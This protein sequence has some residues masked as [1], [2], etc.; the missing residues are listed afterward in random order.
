MNFI[1]LNSKPNANLLTDLYLNVPIGKMHNIKKLITKWIRF[2]P[3]L[4]NS[5]SFV[6]PFSKVQKFHRFVR[7]RVNSQANNMI[8]NTET[9]RIQIIEKVLW[10]QLK[11]FSLKWKE[12]FLT[13]QNMKIIRDIKDLVFRPRKKRNEDLWFGNDLFIL[14]YIFLKK[15]KW[16]IWGSNPWPWRY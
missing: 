5:R 9:F 15:K 7:L 8:G 10:I 3:L 14:N 13:Y 4:R 16:S 2:L 6:L 12:I 11:N 1:T